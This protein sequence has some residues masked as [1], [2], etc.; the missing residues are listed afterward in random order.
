MKYKINDLLTDINF[1]NDSNFC[2]S[3]EYYGTSFIQKLLLKKYTD[4]G[5][6][7]KVFKILLSP[8]VSQKF[9]STEETP[10]SI[11]FR[12]SFCTFILYN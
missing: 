11:T 2:D 7:D 8:S 5:N 9:R 12:L 3:Q 6:L 4:Y 1:C 10:I